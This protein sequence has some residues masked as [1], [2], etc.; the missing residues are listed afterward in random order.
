MSA[1]VLGQVWDYVL[2]PAEQTVLLALADHAHDD[3]TG[4]RPGVG[5]VVWK[6]GLSEATVHR[7]L[8]DLRGRGVLIQTR[9]AGYRRP[10]EYRIVFGPLVRKAA[11]HPVHMGLTVTPIAPDPKGLSGSEM[12]L[13]SAEKGV[14]AV[15]PEPSSEPS[16]KPGAA[17]FQNEGRGGPRSVHVVLDEAGIQAVMHAP[18]QARR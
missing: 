14:A 17:R 6:T 9:R 16:Y 1:K 12:G 13:K 4:V 15:R 3:G 8:R 18:Q 11:Y 5:R 10:A 7:V 2:K